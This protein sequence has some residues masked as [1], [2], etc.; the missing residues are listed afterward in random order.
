MKTGLENAMQVLVSALK[1]DE[2]YY[3]SWQANI[4]MAF[5]DNIEWYK[6]KHEKSRLN[7]KD[8]KEIANESAKYFLNLLI[9]K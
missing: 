3:Y 9:E 5:V 1:E 2:Q 6:E 4:A 8:Y 7:K